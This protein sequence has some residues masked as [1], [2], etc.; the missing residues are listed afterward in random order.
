MEATSWWLVATPHSSIQEGKV[1]EALFEAKLGEAVRDRGP[2]EYRKADV[3]FEKTSLTAGLRQLLLDILRT[4]NGE[5]AANAIVNLKTSFGGGK[6]HTELAIYHLFEHPDVSMQVAQV[7]ELV[8]EAGLDA[9]P[10]CRVACNT[11][12]LPRGFLP[13]FRPLQAGTPGLAQ[14]AR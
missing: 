3:F 10:P 13:K 6:T 11:P 14:S 4:L 5:R 1:N 12:A 8:K 7:R 9:P 2:D